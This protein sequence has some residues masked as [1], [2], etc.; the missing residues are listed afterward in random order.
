MSNNNYPEIEKKSLAEIEK[1]QYAL[2][3]DQLKHISEKS[4]FYK[5]HF[6]ENKVLF[7]EINSL[8][9][10][11]KIPPTTK[12]HLQKFNND[13]ICVN[14]T[15]IVDYITT[16]GTLGDPVTFVLTNSD[17]E[18]LAYN[19]MLTYLLT[20]ISANDSVQLTCTLDKRFMAGLAY[21]MGAKKLGA[22]AIRVGAGIPELQ[23]DSILRFSPSVIVA[24]P[25]FILKLIDYAEKNKI[26]YRSSSVKK[27]ICI[28]EALRLDDFSLT[29]LAAKIKEKWNLK[30]F[31]TY[32]STEMSTAFTECSAGNG[33]HL[34]PDLIIA[35]FLDENDNPVKSGELGE[36]TITTLGVEGMPL[37]RYKTGDICR[38][39]TEKCSCGLT[40]L[41]VGPVIGRKKQMIKFK[42]TT[43]YPPALYEI[44]DNID[45]V[46][47]YIVEVFTNDIGTDEIV[48]KIGTN[49]F[50]EGFEKMIKDHFRA[51]LRVS[52]SIVFDSVDN[53]NAVRMPLTSRKPI[54]FFDKRCEIK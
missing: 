41:R 2:L 20:G 38:H 31:S 22:A 49:S 8:E 53:I 15:E 40:S 29:P 42:G 19:E 51:K 11:K 10:L 14:Q 30:L 7:N 1:F 16:S 17:L 37:L 33:G 13:F 6:K 43:L 52:P 3:R 21:F 28:G 36:V 27:V 26:D 4:D 34:H 5:K 54:T 9:D 24:V 32:A 48:I 18:R 39:F 23:W 45:E 44:L 35:E 46:E 12:E 47:T 25:S 50:S